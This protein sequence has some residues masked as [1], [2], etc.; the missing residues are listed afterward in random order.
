MITD[1]S[2]ALPQILAIDELHKRRIIHRDIKPGNLLLTREGELVVS[3]FGLSRPFGLAAEQQPWTIRNEWRLTS[4]QL[5]NRG[6]GNTADVTYR[7]CGTLGYISPEA[8]CGGPYSYSADVF[9]VGAVI[10]EMLSNKVRG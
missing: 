8:C 4:I 7:N 3:D 1:L 6:D 2:F 9:S 5:A 10:Y